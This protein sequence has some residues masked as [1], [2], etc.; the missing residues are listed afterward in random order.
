MWHISEKVKQQTLFAATSLLVAFVRNR[1]QYGKGWAS[2]NDFGLSWL[3][4]YF[5]LLLIIAFSAAMIQRYSAFFLGTNPASREPDM[6]ELMVC[7]A[8]TISV[9]TAFILL[10]S[11]WPSSGVDF[12]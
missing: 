11:A 8:I 12:I 9:V 6:S 5:G 2:L 10:L 4:H 3:L 1:L 7:S